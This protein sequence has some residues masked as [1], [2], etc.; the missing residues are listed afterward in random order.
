MIAARADGRIVDTVLFLEHRPVITQGRGLQWTGSPRERH[1]PLPPIPRGMEFAESERGGDLTY[2][3]PGQLVIYPLLAT[4]DVAGTLRGV[5][6]A[7]IAWLSSLG[8]EAR[9]HKNATGVWVG[10]KKIGSI[11]IA[12]KK[13]VTY[14]GA[15]INITADLRPFHLIS[16]CGFSPDVMTKLDELL[17]EEH[18]AHGPEWRAIAERTIAAEFTREWGSH[19]DPDDPAAA[20]PT[21]HNLTLEQARS[22]IS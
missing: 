4:R 8:L 7:L 19:H 9:A 15:A 11:G 20:A 12:V 13:W 18:P 22:A 3:G 2:H 5:E 16:P 14:H 21:I 1:M 10:D 17:P 6:R